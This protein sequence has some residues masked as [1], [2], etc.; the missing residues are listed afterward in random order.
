MIFYERKDLRNRA[1]EKEKTEDKKIIAMW[2]AKIIKRQYVEKKY[3]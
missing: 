1:I 2:D 3:P